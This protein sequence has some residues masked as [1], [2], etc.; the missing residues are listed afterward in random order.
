MDRIL[1]IDDDVE[2]CSLVSEYLAPEGFQVESAADGT[3]GLEMALHGEFLLVVL[4][5]MTWV[6]GRAPEKYSGY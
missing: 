4:D 5:V 1:V 2:L 6:A 3:R